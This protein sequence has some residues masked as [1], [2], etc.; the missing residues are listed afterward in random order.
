MTEL[1]DVFLV[2]ARL[3]LLAV[4]AGSAVLADMERESV[5]R[6]WLDHGQFVQA[7]AL[8]QVTPGPQFLFVA[9]VGYYA[10]GLGGATTAAL[11]FFLPP[12][13]LTLA[14]ASSWARTS[15]SPWPDA[16]RR[17]L[18][19]VAI[20]LMCAGLYTIAPTALSPSGAWLI[21]AASL[22][23]LLVQPSRSPLWVVLP[24]AAA[25][26]ALRLAGIA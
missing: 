6:G 2:F 22:A 13:L 7:F 26:A 21:F 18:G 25:G 10:A 3:G 9:V 14:V 17:S 8:S 16:I 11:G 12:G 20:G 23:W 15:L 4:G 1:I 19:P 5:A 24:S